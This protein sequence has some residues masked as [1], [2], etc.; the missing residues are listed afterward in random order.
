M[1]KSAFTDL[2]IQREQDREQALGSLE[3]LAEDSLP[4]FGA[5]VGPVTGWTGDTPEQVP[6]LR[7]QDLIADERGDIV[8]TV[9]EGLRTIVL[10]ADAQIVSRGILP[11]ADIG[12][13]RGVGTCSYLSL[14]SGATLYFSLDVEVLVSEAKG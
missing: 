13:E 1:T 7:L 6:V 14:D 2:S 10:E 12:N 8:I 9:G 5:T 3:R 4:C 11:G